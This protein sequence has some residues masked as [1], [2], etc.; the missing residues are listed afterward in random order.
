MAADQ[1]TKSDQAKEARK[2]KLLTCR[3]CGFVARS[4]NAKKYHLKKEHPRDAK[5]KEDEHEK[6]ISERKATTD[7]EGSEPAVKEKV[8]NIKFQCKFCAKSFPSRRARSRHT[9]S[10]HP[11]VPRENAIGQEENED[12]DVVEEETQPASSAP[13]PCKCPAPGC[14]KVFPSRAVAKKHL[15]KAKGKS[16][17]AYKEENN[18]HIPDVEISEQDLEKMETAKTAKRVKKKRSDATIEGEANEAAVKEENQLSKKRRQKRKVEATHEGESNDT[19]TRKEKRS[20]PIVCRMCEESFSGKGAFRRLM[21]H[22]RKSHPLDKKQKEETENEET[23]SS[24][25]DAK[26]SQKVPKKSTGKKG[27][28]KKSE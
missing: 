16:H 9:T 13:V 27:K 21:Q 28:N 11:R 26:E 4:Q 20:S 6:K 24:E 12:N 5:D 10:V 7:E 17:V 14:G 15:K 8:D 23:K 19:T 3:H 2:K 22:L 1:D 25:V 18:L